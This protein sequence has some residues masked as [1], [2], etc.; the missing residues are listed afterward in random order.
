MKKKNVNSELKLKIREYLDYFWEE[1]R[2]N[3]S[4]I[5]DKIINQLSDSLR[6]ELKLESNKIVLKETPVFS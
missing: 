3:L 4:E 5:E 6:Q 1:Q 2:S